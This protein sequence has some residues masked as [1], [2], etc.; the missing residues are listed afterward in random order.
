MVVESAWDFGSL[1]S[2]VCALGFHRAEGTWPSFDIGLFE[3]TRGL[4]GR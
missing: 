1:I 4:A 2:A 3:V